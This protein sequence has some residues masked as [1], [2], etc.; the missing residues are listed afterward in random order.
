MTS[1]RYARPW[2]AL[3]AMLLGL[4]GCDDTTP[5][6]PQLLSV[7]PPR[8]YNNVATEI[9]ISGLAFHPLIFAD[10]DDKKRSK[11]DLLFSALL[12]A[13]PLANVTYHSDRKLTA[14]VPGGLPPGLLDL[15]VID[16][17]GRTGTLA[18]AFA[19][20]L[21][22]AD[23]GPDAPLLTDLGMDAAPDAASPDQ[24]IDTTAD[25][26]PPDLPSPDTLPPAVVTTV[27]GNGNSGFVDGPAGSAEFA[28]PTSLAVVG[29]VIYISD[30]SNHRIRKIEG[31]QV[32]TVAGSGQQGSGDGDALTA[33]FNFPTALAADSAG[34]L[35]V[36]DSANDLL[37]KIEGGQVTTV[38]GDGTKGSADGAALSAQFNFPRGVAVDG[39][40]IYV[41]DMGNHRVR[42]I[43]GGAVSTL[44]GSAEGY[45]DGLRGAAL[46]SNPSSVAVSGAKIYIADT[47][48]NRIRLIEGDD[49]TTAAGNPDPG[50]D[51]RGALDGPA[52]AARFWNPVDLVMRGDQLVI[53]DQTNHRLRILD[54]GQ[55]WTLSGSTF[56]HLDGPVGA[57]LFFYPQG[58]ALSSPD[59]LY[60]AD[61]SNQRIRLITF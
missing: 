52:S 59:K 3:I 4:A 20:Y 9:E 13:T 50:S 34:A 51:N 28:D 25:S 60:I 45:A 40:I 43:E 18:K 6:G 8:G 24:G 26:T 21:P 54:Q 11:V 29:D 57:A 23:A 36:A 12:G 46:F 15:Q 48:N 31:G 39:A 61:K 1:D 49:V 14:S 58:V 22:P 33:Q 17:R 16:P 44:A 10:H 41:A 47:G 32:T 7:D 30:Y 56:G 37:R 53:V 19:V 35:Y 2:W 55:V 42:V 27:A 38:A 5:P